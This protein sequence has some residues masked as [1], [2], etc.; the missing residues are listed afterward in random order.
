MESPSPNGERGRPDSPERA[1]RIALV[2]PLYESVP[3]KLYGGTERVVSYLAEE[4]VRVG[5][6]VTLFASGDS[7]T[8]ARL[9]AVWD[10]A[11]RMDDRSPEATSLHVLMLEEV[12]ARAR[13]FDVIHFHI[14]AIQ[15]PIAR[16]LGV[17]CVMTMHGR[18]DI[19]GLPLLYRKFSDLPFVSIS[20]AQRLPLPE[21]NW[22]ATIHHGVPPELF[23]AGTEPGAYLAFLGRISPEKRV[24]RAIEIAHKSG[25]PLKIAAKVDRVDREYFEERIEPLI[26]GS[27]IQFVGE[28]ADHEK[29]IFLRDALAVLFPIDWPEPF[30]LV[31]IEAMACGTPVVAF[32]GGSVREVIDEGVTGCVVE[33]IDEAVECVKSMPQW[34]RSRCRAVFEL[35]FAAERMA[36]DYCR[37]YEWLAFAHARTEWPRSV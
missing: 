26:D 27:F 13:E 2:A 37:V 29:A 11:L 10:R 12:C 15:L 3:P 6:D 22:V 18:L 28:V 9:V 7:I 21:A 31:M 16:R 20:N 25:I 5:H 33:S 4:L 8:S 35:R 30:G 19:A 24:D 34:N 14:D 17:P 1:M 32:S 36:R 23:V